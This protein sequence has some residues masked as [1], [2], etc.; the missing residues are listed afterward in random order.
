MLD[1][2]LA[3]D[4]PGILILAFYFS[5]ENSFRLAAPSF[6]RSELTVTVMPVLL[7]VA[8]T[9]MPASRPAWQVPRPGPDSLGCSGYLPLI[10]PPQLLCFLDRLIVLP[11]FTCLGFTAKHAYRSEQIWLNIGG[12]SETY[13]EEGVLGKEVG[14]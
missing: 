1:M 12:K 3:L 8:I 6:P 5:L 13:G 2:A 10:Y 4:L 7:H 14:C 11:L 9:L